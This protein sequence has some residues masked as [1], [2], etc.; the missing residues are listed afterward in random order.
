MSASNKNSVLR[1]DPPESSNNSRDLVNRSFNTLHHS[2]EFN[3]VA[4]NERKEIAWLRHSMKVRQNG[5]AES[6]KVLRGGGDLGSLPRKNRS[7]VP[8]LPPP[9]QDEQGQMDSV[10]RYTASDAPNHAGELPDAADRKFKEMRSLNKMLLSKMQEESSIQ[11]PL[12]QKR[13][14]LNGHQ[15]FSSFR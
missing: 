14:K 10:S 9:A 15:M 8:Q 7:N 12:V 2:F 13:V 5:R 6:N 11:K 1:F 3:R 4:S